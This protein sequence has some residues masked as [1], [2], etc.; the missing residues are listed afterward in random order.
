MD[1]CYMKRQK[2]SSLLAEAHLRTELLE[3]YLHTSVCTAY[4][5]NLMPYTEIML[6]ICMNNHTHTLGPRV[7]GKIDIK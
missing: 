5:K 4:T 3:Y 2:R 1:R 6:P 7:A